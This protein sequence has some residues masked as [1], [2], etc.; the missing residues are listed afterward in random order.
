MAFGLSPSMPAKRG[1]TWSQP[2]GEAGASCHIPQMKPERCS[3]ACTPSSD[4][5]QKAT[6]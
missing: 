5:K 2:W 1:F 6:P 3:I 4:S